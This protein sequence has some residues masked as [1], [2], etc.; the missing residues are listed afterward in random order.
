LEV[1]GHPPSLV[2]LPEPGDTLAG[3]YS[4]VRVIGE[5][6]MGKVYEAIHLRLR[7]R[8][9]IKMLLPRV[10][11]LDDVVARFEREGRMAA[12]LRSRNVARILDVDSTQTGIPYMVMEYLEG[13]DLDVELQQ[14]GML[15]IEEAVSYVCQACEAMEEAHA[16]GIVHRDL[17]PANLFLCPE[18]TGRVAMRNADHRRDDGA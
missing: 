12:Q 9:A 10:V 5:G 18:R 1:V 16:L 11:Q 17:K 14:R 15:P 7:Q 6:G 8:V 2:D 4:I 3:K 13:H